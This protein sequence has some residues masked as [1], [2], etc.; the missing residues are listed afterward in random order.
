MRGSRPGG[1]TDVFDAGQRP[2]GVS[3]GS[4]CRHLRW[5][6]SDYRDAEPEKRLEGASTGSRRACWMADSGRRTA[7]RNALSILLTGSCARMAN[8]R[9]KSGVGPRGV[10]RLNRTFQQKP[11]PQ[12][13]RA[14]SP[15][16]SGGTPKALGPRIPSRSRGARASRL[17]CSRGY[18]ARRVS[19]A[20]R[21]EPVRQEPRDG[22]RTDDGVPSISR[23]APSAVLPASAHQSHR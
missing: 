3:P 16:R 20:I 7:S 19:A 8:T 21:S 1:Y 10:Q 14:P 15:V 6:P 13:G 11:G 18:H 17:P 23:A 22:S 5:R 4:E 2:P 9:R 12:K